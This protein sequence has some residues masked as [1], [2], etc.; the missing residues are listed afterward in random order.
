MSKDLEAGRIR[1]L[2]RRS[3]NPYAS[4]YY[5]PEPTPAQLYVRKL[6]NPYAWLS[7]Q[8]D[9]RE[10]LSTSS[11]AADTLKV[12]QPSEKTADIR[13]AISPVKEV[14]TKSEF[15]QKCRHIFRQYIPEA[16]RGRLRDHHREFIQRN[17]N[18]TPRRRFK[19]LQQLTRY[20]LSDVPGMQSRFNREADIF[21]EDKLRKI[22]IDE[23]NEK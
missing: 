3:E 4:E 1:T 2:I 8:D 22:E 13:I 19:L 5:L 6:Q 23:D 10:V 21:T 16:E 12:Q 18:A 11:T 20:D 7:L 9:E 17:A 15:E 14:V